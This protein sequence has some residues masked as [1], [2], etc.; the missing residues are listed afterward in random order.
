MPGPIRM[1]GVPN[2]GGSL[3]VDGRTKI[4][5]LLTL[6]F[7]FRKNPEHTPVNFLG[8]P[9]LNTLLVTSFSVTETVM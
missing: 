5:H 6:G 1:I 2:D 4:P 7:K 8:F 9:L 3:N